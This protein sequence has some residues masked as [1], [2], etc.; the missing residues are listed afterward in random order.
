MVNTYPSIW[1]LFIRV[2]GYYSIDCLYLSVYFCH[3][4]KHLSF[5]CAISGDLSRKPARVLRQASLL[6]VLVMRSTLN[7]LHCIILNLIDN[8]IFFV[9]MATPVS[10]QISCKGFRMS[11]PLVSISIYVFKEFFIC[12]SVFLSCSIQYSNSS[13]ASSVHDLIIQIHL[14]YSSAGLLHFSHI[15]S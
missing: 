4:E 3:F 7:D 6:L 9:Y 5:L 8:T 14:V 15:F 13:Q 11:Y 12:L 10:R 1:I 2:F